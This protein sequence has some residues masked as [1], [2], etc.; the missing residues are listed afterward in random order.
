MASSAQTKA[1]VA[2]PQAQHA[3]A[4]A[5]LLQRKCACGTHTIG[6]GECDECGKQ[7]RRLQRRATFGDTHNVE[8]EDA[9][10]IVQEVLRSPGRPLDAATRSFMESSIGHDFSRV[11]TVTPQRSSDGLEVGPADDGFER[12]ADR[13]SARAVLAHEP[14]D[15]TARRDRHSFAHVRVHTDERAAQSARAVGALAYTVGNH[16]VFGSGQ[17]APTTAAG[18]RLLAHELVHTLQQ[19]GPGA[20]LRRACDPTKPPLAARTLP[21]Y[22]PNETRI[23]KVF[24]GT[25]TIEV[26]SSASAAIGLVQQAL[27]DLGFD[28][29]TSGPNG[30]GVDRKFG[31]PTK[32]AVSD[33]QRSE[34]IP[35]VKFGVVDQPTIK[36]LDNKRSQVAV[37][38]Q[39]SDVNPEDVRVDEEKA[40]GRD[41]DIFFNRG[42]S[43]LSPEGE[44]KIK[45]LMTRAADPLQGCNVTLEGYESED[46]L[47][48]F[49]EKLA[50][51]RIAAVDKE[52]AAQKHDDPG[53]AC[54]TPVLPLRKSSPLPAVSSGVSDYRGRRKVEVV[55]S[56]KSSTTAPCPP[57]SPDFR[58]LDAAEGKILTDAIALGVKWVNKAISKLN[59][60]DAEGDPALTTYFGGTGHRTKIKN[61][62]KTWVNHLDKVVRKNNR[63]GTDCNA[64]CRKA[65]AFNE[66]TG[67]G[68]QMTACSTFFMPIPLH[69]T[70]TEDEKKAFAI[71]HEAG[72]GSIDTRDTAYGHKRLIEFLADYPDLA[73]TNTDSYTLMILCLNNFP[74][75]CSAPQAKDTATGLS[76]PEETKARRGLGWLQ[77]W[78]VWTQQDTSSMY[79]RINVARESGKKLRDVTDYYADVYDVFVKSFKVR[80]PKDAP[81]T[82][83]EQQTVS[84][85]LDRIIKMED[86]VKAGLDVQKDSS[87][88]VSTWWMF[89]PGRTVFFA[90]DYFVLATD[91]ERVEFLLPLLLRATGDVSSDLESVYKDYIKG[92]VKQ[93]R[94]DKP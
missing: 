12:E 66:G 51:D 36:C 13:I 33:F 82:F 89:G 59:A 15:A 23:K 50:A 94:N 42:E 56:G 16:L 46:E 17:Y 10:S 45:K 3:N 1:Q 62:L 71:M 49:G 88:P 48:E 75:Y 69:P 30:D 72:H 93:S 73:E 63:R 76:A 86:A 52:L 29:G 80:R 28:L 64:V 65:F 24:A 32:S 43:A 31:A 90:D 8:H 58:A 53:P 25:A 38:P 6:G 84:A 83:G 37:Q 74:G 41:E 61:N 39:Q 44:I 19:G 26:G 70:L 68:A 67:S 2:A 92:N 18:R 35:V 21:V 77:T 40:G 57:G 14:N 85:V 22:F 4:R 11:Q 20:T 81:P 54:K 27:V 87:V 60:G 91:R 7:Q 34:A 47:V 9:P 55:P 78:L 79:R 5:G